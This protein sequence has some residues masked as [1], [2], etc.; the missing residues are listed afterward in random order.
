MDLKMLLHDILNE[1]SMLDRAITTN[2]GILRFLFA[3][4]TALVA[5]CVNSEESSSSDA[6]RKTV[7]KG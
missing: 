6:R 2:Y 5:A 3:L 1:D 7:E 4:I